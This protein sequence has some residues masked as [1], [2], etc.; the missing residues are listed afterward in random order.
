MKIVIQRVTQGSVSVEGEVIGEIG[1]GYVILVGIKSGDTEAVVHA[2]AERV[3]NLRIMAD[4]EGK[5][6]LSIMD[7]NGSILAI[8]QFTLYADNKGRRPGFTEAA[9][10]EIAGPLFEKFIET[11]RRKGIKVETGKFGADMKV[12]LINDGPVTVILES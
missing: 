4:E 8:S 3:V 11:L 6:N 7:T 2:M 5:M 12:S 10:P 1:Q 9:R